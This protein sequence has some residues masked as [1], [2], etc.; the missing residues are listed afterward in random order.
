MKSGPWDKYIVMTN[1]NFTRHVGKKNI[2]DLS[3]CLHTFRN[4]YSDHWIYMSNI[5]GIQ[6]NH[7]NIKSNDTLEL[8]LNLTLQ[9]N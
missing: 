2:K 8:V 4:I 1:S 3:I 6:F 5:Y 7:T 9:K